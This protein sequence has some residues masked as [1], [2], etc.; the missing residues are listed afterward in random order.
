M[1]LE[2]LSESE[3]NIGVGVESESEIKDVKDFAHLWW[4]RVALS[5]SVICPSKVFVGFVC[6][7]LL[8]LLTWLESS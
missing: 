8:N 2:K 6:C 7:L 1:I 3:L 5:A 4:H